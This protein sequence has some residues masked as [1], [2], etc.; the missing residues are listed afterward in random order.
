[1]GNGEMYT[2]RKLWF[3]DKNTGKKAVVAAECVNPGKLSF[4]YQGKR[5]AIPVSMLGNRIYGCL[6]EK[7]QE[8]ETPS[9]EIFYQESTLDSR[10]A[11]G[12]QTTAVFPR[13]HIKE[14]SPT[15]MKSGVST[16]LI[17]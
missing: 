9:K 4:C 16:T 10:T 3:I 7:P 5:Y 17:R 15:C 6:P 8:K 1:M 11:N 13:R 12:Y 14:G 2:P